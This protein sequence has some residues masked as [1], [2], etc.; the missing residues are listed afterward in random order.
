M[1]NND[2]TWVNKGTDSFD[3]TIGLFDSAQTA[4]IV[5]IYILDT[6][7]RITNLSN[8]VIYGD[9]DIISIYSSKEPLTSK[10]QKKVITTFT[11]MVLNIEISS[12][13]KIFRCYFQLE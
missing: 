1:I 13:L 3:V 12:N 5:S 4:D 6:R 10:I 8:I 2:I 9:D 11:Y 7:S